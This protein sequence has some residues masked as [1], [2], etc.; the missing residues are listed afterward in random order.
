MGLIEQHEQ[1]TGRT[2]R[3]AVGDSQ[4]GTVENF[5]DCRQRGICS[6]VGT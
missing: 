5:R 2:V 3:T 6:H 4:Y 1:N